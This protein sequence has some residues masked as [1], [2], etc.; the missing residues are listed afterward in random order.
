M[1]REVL[2]TAVKKATTVRY[3]DEKPPTVPGLHG[4]VTW[5]MARCIGCGRCPRVCPSEAIELQ[6]EPRA[7]EIIYH[8]DRCLFCGECMEICPTQAIQ[9]TQMYELATS[10][11][12]ALRIHFTR[13][14][15]DAPA[16]VETE[17][18]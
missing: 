12:D 14:T 3:P 5:V 2:H 9:M 7:P 17:T 8:L 11:R 4:R 6:G 15:P 16:H 18:T 13:A 10:H 1:E